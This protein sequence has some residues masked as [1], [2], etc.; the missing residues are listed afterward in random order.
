MDGKA[1]STNV[2]ILAQ[3]KAFSGLIDPI[4]ADWQVVP[5][6]HCGTRVHPANSSREPQPM[7]AALI[8]VMSF[9]MLI[10]FAVTSWRSYW[11]SLAQQR[12]S[13]YM[14]IATGIAREAISAS[15]F[16]VL[17]RT[18]ESMC[19]AAGT[20]DSKLSQVRMYFRVIRGIEAICAKSAPAISD[21]AKKELVACSRYAAAVLDQRLNANLKYVSEL[22]SC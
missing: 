12:P 16:D 10:Q 15:H 3:T 20:G 6:F 21:W 19:P 9:G 8:V 13:N 7:I 17:A 4:A 14:E 22:G 18:A 1:I 2:P 5:S 11:L